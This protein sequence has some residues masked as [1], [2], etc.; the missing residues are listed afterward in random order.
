MTEAAAPLPLA[1]QPHDEFLWLEDIHG[2]DAMA[3]VRERN[4]RTD[5]A[6]VNAAYTDLEASVLEVLDS[7]DRIPMV[8]KRGDWYYNFWRDAAN[9]RGL[10]R[11]TTWESYL[12]SAPQWE[13]LL[14]IDALCASSGKD[15]FWAGATLL[16]PAPGEEYRHV[17]VALSPDGGDAVAYREFDLSTLVLCRAVLNFR[18][19]K[20]ASAGWIRTRCT[21]APTRARAP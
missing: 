1:D 11:R 12:S 13:V 21:S 7:K 18:R 19:R 6:L 14:D 5:A 8:S 3:W 10:W 15:W 20:L 9:P 17:M 2:D 4:A 16:R